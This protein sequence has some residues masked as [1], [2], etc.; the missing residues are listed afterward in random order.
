[1]HPLRRSIRGVGRGN[2][3]SPTSAPKE[4]ASPRTLPAN[5]RRG[6]SRRAS[7]CA[8]ARGRSSASGGTSQRRVLSSARHEP[9]GSVRRWRRGRPRGGT[10]TGRRGVG[11]VNACG[12]VEPMAGNWPCRPLP[13]RAGF[14]GKLVDL[15]GGFAV[16]TS[17]LSGWYGAGASGLSG[18]VL[19]EMMW[20]VAVRSW[21]HKA[22]RLGSLPR[23]QGCA[24]Y[25]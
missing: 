15:A 12:S 7:A 17:G 6:A 8:G 9:V 11:G 24:K 19:G 5:D 3:R 18:W 22:E 4:H 25:M 21:P 10:R 23:K 20:G 1:M 13:A 2:V 16:G 14:P